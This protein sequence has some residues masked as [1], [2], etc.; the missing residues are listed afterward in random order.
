MQTTSSNYDLLLLFE[1]SPQSLS[2]EKLLSFEAFV[3]TPLLLAHTLNRIAPFSKTTLHTPP[4]N[5]AKAI[6]TAGMD[7]GRSY[8]LMG[9]ALIIGSMQKEQLRKSEAFVNELLLQEEN[10]FSLLEEN[11]SK[12][13]IFLAGFLVEASKRFE[14]VLGGGFSLATA[15][16]IAD[17]LRETILM[18]P[19]VNN[20]LYVSTEESLLQEQLKKLFASLS[21]EQKALYMKCDFAKNDAAVVQTIAASKDLYTAATP[22][23]FY[24]ALGHEIKSD[25]LLDE[26]ELSY[27]LL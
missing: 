14:I 16:L 1:E 5:D 4:Q 13:L 26:M 7:F 24:Y 6:F 20:I 21:Y 3:K 23:L 27:Y 8:E 2:L 22:A 15:L 12:T 17:R 25:T 9:S 11:S 19:N 18:R 10:L